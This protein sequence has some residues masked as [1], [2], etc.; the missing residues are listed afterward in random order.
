MLRLPMLT[1]DTKKE[2]DF[3]SIPRIDKLNSNV[4]SPKGQKIVIKGYGF[5]TIKEEI[6]VMHGTQKCQVLFASVKKIKCRLPA[7]DDTKHQGLK[8]MGQGLRWSNYSL[9]GIG[10]TAEEFVPRLKDLSSYTGKITLKSTTTLHDFEIPYNDFN[11]YLSSFKGFFKA[12]KTGKFKF[13]A[14]GDDSVAFYLSSVA[15]STDPSNLVKLISTSLWTDFRDYF[16]YPTSQ[17]SA[18]VDLTAD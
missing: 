11:N 14:S 8:L 17:V 1:A 2:Y 6:E 12:P 4:G 18:E 13:Y 5:S 10:G 7:Y 3:V 9:S 15:G 16:K